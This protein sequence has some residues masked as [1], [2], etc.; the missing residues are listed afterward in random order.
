MA[1]KKPRTYTQG[2]NTVTAQALNQSLPAN[3]NAVKAL[4]GT[5]TVL[6]TQYASYLDYPFDPTGAT[7]T[8]DFSDPAYQ[9]AGYCWIP[10][11]GLGSLR[12]NGG[13]AQLRFR[14]GYL[15]SQVTGSGTDDR[16]V[17]FFYQ[18]IMNDNTTA[19]IG[20]AVEF[21]QTTVTRTAE[22]GGPD[23]VDV[24]TGWV[25]VTGSGRD[26]CYRLSMTTKI[27]GAGSAYVN[28]TVS[29]LYA[30]VEARAS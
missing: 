26:T 2:S 12:T 13:S 28:D 11:A 30:I 27:S 16:A 5:R 29:P 18:V 7:L 1:F 3:L 19:S 17:R 24:D 23:R 15:F 20:T 10:W 6:F 25:D 21:P 14:T 4:A 9:S 8:W 22:A